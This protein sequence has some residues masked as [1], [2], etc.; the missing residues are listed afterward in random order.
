MEKVLAESILHGNVL[1]YL[2]R[3]LDVGILAV[4]IKLNTQIRQTAGFSLE[5]L[6]DYLD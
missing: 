2:S 1:T 3:I 5:G 4:C 6:A